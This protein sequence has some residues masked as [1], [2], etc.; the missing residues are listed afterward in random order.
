MM[1]R[2]FD[3][4]SSYSDSVTSFA[5]FID[6]HQHEFSLTVPRKFCFAEPRDEDHHR[7]KRLF[8]PTLRVLPEFFNIRSLAMNQETFDLTAHNTFEL[9]LQ[10]K[11]QSVSLP[12]DNDRPSFT[13][14]N[15]ITS[16]IIKGLNR[17][18]KALQQPWQYY[19][20]FL[21]DFC[22]VQ[23]I[24]NPS[25]RFKMS[26]ELAQTWYKTSTW[27][28]TL[29]KDSLFEASTAAGAEFP[30]ANPYSL[31]AP[32]EFDSI[33]CRIIIPPY[34]SISISNFKVFEKLGFDTAESKLQPNIIAKYKQTW[35]DNFNS[36]EFLIIV[37]NNAPIKYNVIDPPIVTK[38][39]SYFNQHHFYDDSRVHNFQGLDKVEF[40]QEAV[41]DPDIFLTLV[42]KSLQKVRN[43]FNFNITL[44]KTTSTIM[45]PT[46]AALAE[47]KGGE[48]P[49]L[50]L[51]VS[52]IVAFLLGYG[53]VNYI[54]SKSQKITSQSSQLKTS[55]EEAAFILS[56]DT[57][58]ILL[59]SEYKGGSMIVG[60]NDSLIAEL[61]PFPE[62]ILALASPQEA[63]FFQ[64]GEE[65]SGPEITLR[66]YLWTLNDRNQR[67]PFNWPCKARIVGS[68]KSML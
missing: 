21:I 57:A 7:A 9:G 46:A 65:L 66:F 17:A 62:G 51:M 5:I 20:P 50:R 13:H 55:F 2:A 6:P 31:P 63:H 39:I 22:S 10:F 47:A 56:F 25:L 61:K 12:N 48:I 18:G 68:L 64:L 16:E 26:A 45:F 30:F 38:T 49:I 29:Y 37:A 42:E 53:S 40:T 4:S 24:R 67:I 11:L 59:T 41:L 36:S 43:K 52:E 58:I 3:D 34:T 27:D 32:T 15:V 1:K 28:E 33:R 54:D 19:Q 8:F 23:D 60:S 44:N 14:S 35:L